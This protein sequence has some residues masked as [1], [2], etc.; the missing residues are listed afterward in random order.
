MLSH[1]GAVKVADF[2]LGAIDECR[3]Q[4]ADPSGRH[5]GHAALHESQSKS[6]GASLDIRSDIY[7]LGV[8]CYHLLSGLAPFDGDTALAIA[9]KHVNSTPEP[10]ENVQPSLP[11]SLARI[12]HHML[13][14]KTE[15]RPASPGELLVALRT[16][17]NSAAEEGW[18]DKPEAWT[19][20]DWIA[21]DSS[22]E[23]HQKL[24]QLMKEETRLETLSRR[25]LAT[26]ALVV[27]SI[28]AGL[29][30]ASRWR[31]DSYLRGGA[32]PTIP[33]RDSVEAQ[34]YHA[35]M[36][37]SPAA[38]RSVEQFFPEADDYPLQLARQGL[39]R[40]YLMVSQE[41]Q[42]ALQEVRLLEEASLAD[43]SNERLAAFVFAAK[44][45]ASANLGHTAE[46]Q[47]A[48]DQLTSNSRDLLRTSERQLSDLLN[49][50]TALLNQ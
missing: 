27:A 43:P 38:W 39:V 12:V 17:A 48:L 44:C 41:Y 11:S 32:A 23:S 7:S 47:A 2:G 6:R 20:A 46:A 45:I 29:F 28:L 18:A 8:T 21:T 42:R 1:T 3:H 10:L 13:S 5:H 30:L 36:T 34:L 19:L 26:A 40:Y 14:K 25:W 49:S 33:R 37:N 50:S 24:G 9:M 15:N 31:G 35:K 22:R 4:D 16:L